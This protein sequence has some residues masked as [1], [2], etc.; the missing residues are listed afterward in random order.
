M[1][2]LIITGIIIGYFLLGLLTAK[3]GSVIVRDVYI[4]R[5]SPDPF[6]VTTTVMLWPLALAMFILTAIGAGISKVATAFIMW[7]RK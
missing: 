5:N 7:G 4:D 6:V 1:L 3:L 2:G